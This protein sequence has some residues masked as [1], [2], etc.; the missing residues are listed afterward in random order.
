MPQRH[1]PDS[2]GTSRV[3]RSLA[4]STCSAL[5]CTMTMQQ[6]IRQLA[7]C[8]VQRATGSMQRAACNRQHTSRRN[9]N[10]NGK[11]RLTTVA[12]CLLH[13]A[14]C[15]IACAPCSATRSDAV[16]CGAVRCG[17]VPAVLRAV[18]S[19]CREGPYTAQPL[20]TRALRARRTRI[21]EVTATHSQRTAERRSAMSAVMAC[22][23]L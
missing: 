19:C 6:H 1:G 18:S 4:S 7:A 10:G 22:K 23:W 13:A 11:P 20:H 5:E 21:L 2:A 14:V 12:C 9:G 17:A 15:C 8:S 16:R 3:S